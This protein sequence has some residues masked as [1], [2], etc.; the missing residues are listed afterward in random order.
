MHSA[1][2]PNQQIPSPQISGDI[3]PISL[4]PNP[5]GADPSVSPTPKQNLVAPAQTLSEQG[6]S[7][8]HKK[9]IILIA[10]ILIL[11]GIAGAAAYFM[12][13][14]KTA[15]AP[16]PSPTPEAMMENELE[17]EDP[18][19]NWQTYTNNEYGF[20]FKYPPNWMQEN[21][22]VAGAITAV[23]GFT[24]TSA[25]NNSINYPSVRMIYYQNPKAAT[26]P[27]FQIE[28]SS[29]YESTPPTIYTT[30]SKEIDIGNKVG[31]YTENANC[32]PLLCDKFAFSHQNK[33]FVFYILYESQIDEQLR[34][35]FAQIL[36]TFEFTNDTN[37]VDSTADWQTYTNSQIGV[38]FKVINIDEVIVSSNLI[39]AAKT[40]LGT[41]IYNGKFF[42]S[43]PEICDPNLYL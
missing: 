25:S 32:E 43:L 5:V 20:S 12:M 10:I 1:A 39:E 22:E 33:V 42:D 36:S 18:N 26:V 19:A 2:D 11:I 27:N 37:S 40:K 29:Q 31:Y 16:T 34:S 3:P 8:D 35:L 41:I 23:A 30:D 28:L 6:E 17:Q 13:N 9:L 15:V 14:P 4:D 21:L 38:T 24:P 7:K